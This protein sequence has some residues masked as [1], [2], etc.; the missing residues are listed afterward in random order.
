MDIFAVTAQIWSQAG[1]DPTLASAFLGIFSRF[2]FALKRE[3][4]LTSLKEGARAEPNWVRFTSEL[5]TQCDPAMMAE[6]LAAGTYLSGKP[7]RKQI[8][9]LGSLGWEAEP[10]PADSLD[11]LFS[12]V[13]TTRNNL[14]HGG[15]FPV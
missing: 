13:R 12:A 11:A 14:F 5:A 1:I 9:S 2:E 4:F 7:S 8:V 3:G 15:K 6:I 10:P